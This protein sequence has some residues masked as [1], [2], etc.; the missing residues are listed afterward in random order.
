[1]AN[2]YE[3]Y[4]TGNMQ[5]IYSHEISKG[6]MYG[7]L[8]LIRILVFEIY[9]SFLINDMQ[10]LLSKV[11]KLGFWSKKLRNVRKIIKNQFS[12]FCDFSF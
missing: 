11:A 5:Q 3:K 9:G 4:L 8:F 1:M 12:D 2:I 7:K 10:T 6:K